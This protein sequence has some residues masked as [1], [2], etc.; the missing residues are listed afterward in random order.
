[1]NRLS[2]FLPGDSVNSIKPLKVAFTDFKTTKGHWHIKTG[3]VFK[4]TIERLMYYHK[5]PDEKFGPS[6]TFSISD[7]TDNRYVFVDVSARLKPL[8]DSCSAVL[9]VQIKRDDEM[10]FW[11][12]VN[13]TEFGLEQG[14]WQDIYIT[15]N[16]QDIFKNKMKVRFSDFKVFI[17]NPHKEN[18]LLY[19]MQIWLR[20][21]NPYRYS[22]FSEI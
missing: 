4:D 6:C 13:F 21:G 14:K 15:V 7:V 18:F 3:Q 11:K 22:L 10:I 2:T 20:P 19:D 8:T 17:W 12:G 5:L 1:M 16:L 9:V